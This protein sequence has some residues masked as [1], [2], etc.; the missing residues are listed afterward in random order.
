MKTF[1]EGS[2]AI[3]KIV[4]LCRPGVIAAYPITPQTHI[5]EE[6]AQIVA[7]GE[8]KAEFVNVES[9]HSA[10]SVVLGAIATGVRSYT[11]SSSQ[12]LLLMAEVLYNIAGM[13]LPLVLTCANRA[14]SAPINI[15]NDHQDSV[16]L[17]DSGLIQF[18]AETN[19]ESVDLHILAFKIAED[20]R[21]GL[22]VMVCVDG[23]LLTHA[24][25]VVDIPSQGTIDSYLP[26]YQA[27]DK[28]DVESPVSMGVWFGPE[29]YM[30]TRYAIQ[31]TMK[32]VQALI[33][34]FLD[35]FEN[36]V[37][38]R[39]WAVVEPYRIEDA[40]RAVVAM[41]SVVG[42]V[43]EVV[44]DMRNKGEKVGV[45]KIVMYRPFPEELIYETL[46]DVPQI[47]VLEKSISLGATGPLY[48]D[49]KS[50]FQGR[51]ASPKISGFVI[52]LG[53]RDITKDSIHRVFS[54]L[55]EEQVSAKFMDLNLEQVE[56]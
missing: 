27:I 28:L 50:V 39:P 6:L 44:D 55:R 41:G 24:Y 26:A 49:L 56:K 12:G 37:K 3:A 48:T 16:T 54:A 23:Y 42:T 35:E 45:L 21:V 30:E 33:P 34:E 9:E 18:Y 22:P 20:K 17:R 2:V 7:N 32:E 13:R 52:G 29:S 46:K 51:R 40:E 11:A 5:V 47:A 53:G 15:W 43:K 8:L 36:A 4:A 14:V 10:A 25:E 31:E 1:I 38:R 19:Q